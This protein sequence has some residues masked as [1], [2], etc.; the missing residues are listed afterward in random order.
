VRRIVILVLAM[1]IAVATA[2]V[3]L[4]AASPASARDR[5]VAA[6]LSQKSVHWTGR[7]S[8]SGAGT[9]TF[10]ADVSADAGTAREGWGFP[11]PA[12]IRLVNDTVYV[13][14]DST[15]LNCC[16]LGLTWKQAWRYAGKWISIPKGDDSYAR[17]ADGLTLASIV[18]D[19]VPQGTSKSYT[20]R[21]GGTRFLAV[22][23]TPGN[24]FWDTSSSGRLAAHG[25]GEPLPVSFSYSDV[26]SW[27]HGRFSRW[28]EP[29]TVRAPERSTP[30]ATVR[31]S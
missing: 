5:I 10:I 23:G 24:N 11:G 31:G 6:A 18:H 14:A 16:A 8:A 13:K 28:N 12:Q 27:T 22:Q 25:S 17:L 15:V 2:V 26:A 3:L 20:T 4:N 1:A 9:T 7:Y 29:L 30:I 19:A 21:S